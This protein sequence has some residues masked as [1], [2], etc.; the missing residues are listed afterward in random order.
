M[1]AKRKTPR[2]AFDWSP[3]FTVCRLVRGQS[4]PSNARHHRR[5]L[6]RQ[7]MKLPEVGRFNEVASNNRL[8]ALFILIITST[9]E[10]Y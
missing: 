9:K 1:L 6:G 8:V 5:R 10:K 4:W 3:G 2:P 7:I